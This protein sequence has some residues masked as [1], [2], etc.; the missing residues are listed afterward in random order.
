M[1]NFKKLFET[2]YE[3]KSGDEKNFKEKHIVAKYKTPFDSESQ[4][5]SKLPKAKRKADHD[6]GEDEDVYEAIDVHTKRADKEPVVVRAVDPKTGQSKAKTVMRRAGE[7]KIGEEVDLEESVDPKDYSTRGVKSQFGGYRA[8]IKHKTKGHTMYS[9]GHAYE[10]A[11]KAKGEADAYLKGYTAPGGMGNDRH[12]AS[13]ANAHA[14]IHAIKG[15]YAKKSVKEETELSEERVI[16]ATDIDYNYAKKMSNDALKAGFKV[17]IIPQGGATEIL[18]LGDKAAIV[19]FLKARRFDQEEIDDGMLDDKMAA[20]FFAHAGIKEDLDE[21]VANPYA[22]GMAAAMKAADDTPPLKKS[23]IVKGHEIAKSIMKKEA[24]DPVGKEDSDID[25]DGDTDKSDKYLHA[26]RKAI[27]KALRK[28][29]ADLDEAMIHSMWKVQHPTKPTQSYNVKART[30]GEAIKKAHKAAIDAGHMKSNVPD[31]AFKSKHIQ[32]VNEEVELD[33]AVEVRHDRYMRSHG[34]KASGGSGQWMFTHKDRGDVNYNDDKEVHTAN[35]KFADAKK[36]AQAWA[37]KH[38]HSSVYV[39]EGVEELEE[40][41][42]K[43]VSSAYRMTVPLKDGQ[44]HPDH[45]EKINDLKAK[46]RADNA[47]EGTKN[48]VVL[49]GRLGKDNPNA[50]KYKSK[51]TGKSFPGSHQRI[52]LGDASHADVYVR[53]EVEELDEISQETLRSY[54]AKAGSDRLKAK[55]EVQKGMAQKKFTPASVQKTT[56]SYKRFIKRGKGMTAAANKMDEEVEQ[57]DEISQELATRAFA[58]RAKDA[59]E[60]GDV[61]AGKESDKSYDKSQKTLAMIKKKYGKPGVDKAHQQSSALVFGGKKPYKEEVEMIDEAVKVGAMKLHDGATVNVTRAMADTLNGVFE[62]LNP[63]NRV[64][65]EQ[66]LHMSKKDFEEIL[67]FAE[68]VN[69]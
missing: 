18:L 57:I 33:E 5:T 67:K 11:S 16:F 50:S 41:P 35:G 52:K 27:G 2:V 19:K 9:G 65:M 26:R 23:T 60:Y 44:V 55:A 39:M 54:H 20:K 31:T 29:E 58:R 28:E 24:M 51:F 3:P 69:G 63:T 10:T 68:N 66:K 1:I 42:G 61:G 34:K 46:V 53:E 56:D 30:A 43:R 47:K 13:L 59:F 38:G 21:K 15:P 40:A 12:A 4:F 48:K 62:Q 25:N 6:K 49:Q 45:A 17:R 64:K 37:K 8:E 14:A 7:I 36:S 32:K 22:V